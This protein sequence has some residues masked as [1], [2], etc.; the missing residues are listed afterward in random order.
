MKDENGGPL[1]VAYILHDDAWYLPDSIAS[2]R[3][4]G[5]VFAFVSKVPWH[6]LPGDWEHAAEVARAA[7]AEVVLGEWRSE[8][9][10]RA[11]AFDYLRGLAA[12]ET[13]RQGDGESGDDPTGCPPQH[14]ALSTQYCLIPDGDE[15]IEPELLRALCNVAEMDLADRVY[16]QWDTYWKSREYVIRPREQFTPCILVNL[17][18][19]WPV[20]LRNFEGGRPLLLSPEHGIIHHLSYC[21]PDE[22]IQRKLATWGHRDEVVPGWYENVWL[23]WDSDKLLRNL[24]PT[25]PGAYGFAERLFSPLRHRDTEVAQSGVE[26]LE[27]RVECETPLPAKA[28]SRRGA[29]ASEAVQRLEPE[30]GATRVSIV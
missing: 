14:S 6:D 30:R 29:P 27:S 24:H 10:Q 20:G 21:G 22:R 4:A 13:G 7:G 26:S 16:V 25:H 2:F 9:E 19:A 15:I 11:A 1:A 18:N 28:G 23:A 3:E 12:K 5:P 17:H 8:L